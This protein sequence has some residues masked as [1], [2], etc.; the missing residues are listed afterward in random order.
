MV[1]H[2]SKVAVRCTRVLYISDGNIKGE[3]LNDSEKS[4]REETCFQQ[5]AD[6][7]WL[8]I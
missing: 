1:A 6:G 2:D 8:V 7:F 4:D 3:F 5:L